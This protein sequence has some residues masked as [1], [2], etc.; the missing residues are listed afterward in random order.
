MNATTQILFL[1][2]ET[3]GGLYLAICLLR[4]LLQ[5]SRADYYN[6]VSQAVV[7]ATGVP[8]SLLRRVIPSLGRLDGAALVWAVLVQML[9]IQ[10]LALVLSGGLVPILTALTWGVIGLL[11]LTL[12]LY[13]Y[14]I[15]IVIIASFLIALG[16]LRLSHPA[17]D[18]VNQLMEPVM[19]PFRRVLP[20]LGGLDLSP[21]L[22]FLTIRVLQVVIGNLAAS[23][24]LS[25]Q[26]ARLVPGI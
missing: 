11:N 22:I 15:F 21:I 25:Y 14:G 19:A 26:L 4:V 5:V 1:I 13:F 20:P 23:A 12:T 16:G 10:L 2:L 6:P 7:K 24:G 8:V 3:V 17:L 9:L 18:L